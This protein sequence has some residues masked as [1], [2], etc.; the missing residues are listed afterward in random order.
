MILVKNVFDDVT[1]KNRVFVN[2]LKRNTY[3]KAFLHINDDVL[4]NRYL[5][6]VSKLSS[7]IL[8]PSFSYSPIREKKCQ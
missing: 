6:P 8:L 5:Y 3:S 1:Q 7:S 4:L 2:S